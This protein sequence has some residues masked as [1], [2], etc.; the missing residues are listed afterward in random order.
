[1]PLTA[2]GQA[3]GPVVDEDDA[4]SAST[5]RTGPAAPR[6]RVRSFQ[7]FAMSFAIIQAATLCRATLALRAGHWLKA[8]NPV[9]MT[10]PPA[11]GE[12]IRT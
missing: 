1:M 6:Q 10:R 9:E 4:L 2:S 3:S 11:D 12:S 5:H 7:E 8:V